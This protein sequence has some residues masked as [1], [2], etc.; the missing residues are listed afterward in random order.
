MKNR[1][2]TLTL[3]LHIYSS[4]QAYFLFAIQWQTKKLHTIFIQVLITQHTSLCAIL[5]HLAISFLGILRLLSTPFY[6]VNKPLFQPTSHIFTDYL[7]FETFFNPKSLKKSLCYAFTK[8]DGLPYGYTPP[9]VC[10]IC[11]NSK[12]FLPIS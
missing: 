6:F 11:P 7:T 4:I 12:L 5:T 9:L 10:L 3:L 2:K 8:A 1:S